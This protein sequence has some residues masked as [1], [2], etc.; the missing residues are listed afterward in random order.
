MKFITK[1][2][3]YLFAFVVVFAHV[4]TV[5]AKRR[6]NHEESWEKNRQSEDSS[7]ESGAFL[8]ESASD[9][10]LVRAVN[11]RRRE[12]F[13]EGGRLT[14]VKIL[15]DDNSGLEHQKWVVRLSNG[16]LMQAVYN[17]D[18]CPRVPLNVG[19]VIAMGGQFIWTNKGGLLHWLHHDPR[20][21]RPDGYVYVNGQYYCKE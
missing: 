19:D 8:D 11:E 18:M 7:Y 3:I 13:V 2:S 5:E 21:R 12:D 10:D 14:V 1:I 9:S 4:E 20:G 17:L 16:E 6:N 15:P